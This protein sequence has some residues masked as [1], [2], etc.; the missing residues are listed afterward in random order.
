[1]AK[2]NFPQMQPIQIEEPDSLIKDLGGSILS[3][4]INNAFYQMRREGLSEKAS[5]WDSH[6]LN[7]ETA[8]KLSDVSQ[9]EQS[10]N[11]LQ[12]AIDNPKTNASDVNSLQGLS[13]T[14]NVHLKSLYK[15]MPSKNI[16]AIKDGLA[17][18]FSKAT[19]INSPAASNPKFLKEVIKDYDEAI[20][21]KSLFTE[22]IGALPIL[23][24]E[25]E[26]K[27]KLFIEK[28]LDEDGAFKENIPFSTELL[29]S[30]RG[31]QA[32]LQSIFQSM[33]KLESDY[34]TAIED[35]VK[36]YKE[37]KNDP[38]AAK[39]LD[40]L[41]NQR[42]LIQQQEQSANA[43]VDLSRS[44]LDYGNKLDAL[45]KTEDNKIN[46]NYGKASEELLLDLSNKLNDNARFLNKAHVDELQELQNE[47]RAITSSLDVINRVE[48]MQTN[49]V[50]TSPEGKL[51]LQVAYD[52]AVRGY[53]NEDTAAI[54]KAISALNGAINE[55]SRLKRTQ[56]TNLRTDKSNIQKSTL[57]K[58][59]VAAGQISD[60]FGKGTK[61]VDVK[62][63]F[64]SSY[65]EKGSYEVIQDPK[66]LFG[67]FDISNPS[68][69]ESY[70]SAI[71]T[72]VAKLVKSSDLPND[73]EQV[74]LLINDAVR[75]DVK[76]LDEL[77]VKHLNNQST[78]LDFEGTRSKD[79]NAQN[80]YKQYLEL[81][82][83]LH[84]AELESY[85][86][87][88]DDFGQK[89]ITDYGNGMTT[90]PLT[91]EILIQ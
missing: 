90:D 5:L 12:I 78:D 27:N 70:K 49:N 83:I 8:L 33:N 88:G 28:Y 86:I 58:L 68:N 46:P 13:N 16:D 60:S 3:N 59:N 18:T 2:Y 66:S 72:Q 34:F 40:I 38:L 87:L 15:A 20:N 7:A 47:A 55:E 57:A 73:N 41:I 6:K 14:L 89:I 52:E 22:K 77:F 9:V 11:E 26:E 81:Y 82:K 45:R 32:Y 44:M 36:Y 31:D 76:A 4:V 30:M 25:F 74:Q 29:E 43:S 54:S 64:D 51:K 61:S 56:A 48:N 50:I 24:K 10:I 67:S 17:E 1:M 79:T 53:T 75:G 91:G 37:V 42:R 71:G 85:S 63:N 35:P 80:L 23:Q 21:E 69:I 39:E 65:L 62:G 19:S 84:D